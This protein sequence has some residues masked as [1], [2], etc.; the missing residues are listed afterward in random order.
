M[1]TGGNP[2]HEYHCKIR[3]ALPDGGPHTPDGSKWTH[4]YD[5]L[6]ARAAANNSEDSCCL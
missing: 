4:Q 2:V 6:C 3:E 5:V 1:V